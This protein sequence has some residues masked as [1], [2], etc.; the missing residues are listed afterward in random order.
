MF[1]EKFEAVVELGLDT[2]EGFFNVFLRCSIVSV[3]EDVNAVGFFVSFG[4]QGVNDTHGLECI[5]AK[6]ETVS[7]FAAGGIKVDRVTHDAEIA[8]LEGEVVAVIL[9]GDEIFDKV[10]LRNNINGLSGLARSTFFCERGG[11]LR[12]ELRFAEP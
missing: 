2:N 1:F 7:P 3:G 12:I 4:G 8:P 10:L 5:E 6:F 9:H 11:A